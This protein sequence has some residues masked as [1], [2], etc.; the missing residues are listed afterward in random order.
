MISRVN[1]TLREMMPT[2]VGNTVD[3]D[4]PNLEGLRT[5]LVRHN[6]ET[7]YVVPGDWPAVDGR[8]WFLDGSLPTEGTDVQYL[9]DGQETFACMVEA[10]ETADSAG[11]F[12][13]LLG[14]SL[15]PR[16]VI[17]A[18]N[19]KTVVQVLE[20]RASLGVAVRVLLFDNTE[21][22]IN[23]FACDKINQIRTNSSQDVYAVLDDHTDSL[24]PGLEGSFELP[25]IP[26]FAPL[27]ESFHRARERAQKYTKK[28]NVGAVG[29]HHHKIMLVYGRDGLVGFCGGID[30]DGNRLSSLHDVHVR[31]V[32]AAARE[33][34]TIA[35][36][37]WA[38]SRDNGNAPTP[39]T[40]STLSPPSTPK[41][42][43]APNAAKVIQTV[44]NPDIKKFT[45]NTLWPTI[46][47]AVES[48][49]SFIYV[50]DQ[51]FWSLDLVDALVRAAKSDAVRHI[52]ILLP[53]ATVGEH[54]K[55]RQTAIGK[56]VKDAGETA[57][58]KFGIYEMQAPGHEWVHSKLFVFDDEFAVVGSANANNRGYFV[59]SEAA[60][61]VAEREFRHPDGRWRSEWSMVEAAWA[62][63]L[64]MSL[65]R[66]HLGL[67]EAEVFDGVGA[68]VHWQSP[69][70]AANI[71]VY[72]SVNL[73]K[74]VRS[75]E[76][77]QEEV[78]EG[79][80]PIWVDPLTAE[81][82]RPW[83]EGARGDWDPGWS[84]EDP[85]VDP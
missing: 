81:D 54:A 39:S 31:V 3:P 18:K 28:G 42:A 44:G 70:P 23:D 19:K 73:N 58:K 52:T 27:P 53:K 65:W 6:T 5:A 59:D 38:Y 10:I 57:V 29:A 63:R 32:G 12:I 30:I 55:R 51:Y 50:E 83:W 17:D 45:S 11:H 43:F 33:L 66:E 26:F 46:Q 4:Y 16:V 62:R 79:K 9:V 72:N 71:G 75:V 74:W 76:Q 2:L 64:R 14:W 82:R 60:V 34:L 56:L 20:Q 69:P 13:V 7:T 67:R 22:Q 77:Y 24:T 35:E 48:A 15:D 47:R 37:R 68:R 36:Q 84:V 85:F 78:A 25:P 8:R 49:T 61:A 80:N 21:Y 1:L 40:I 41:P